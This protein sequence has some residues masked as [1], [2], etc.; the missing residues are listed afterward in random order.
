[1]YKKSI[2]KEKFIDNL[3]FLLLILIVMSIAS[4]II[5]GD[6]N[7]LFRMLRLVYV[8]GMI[9]FAG[10][11]TS[12]NSDDHRMILKK[13]G[14][15]FALFVILGT[16]K[17]TLLYHDNIFQIFIKIITFTKIPEQTEIFFTMLVVLFC[18]AFMAR[19][20][21]SISQHKVL[22]DIRLSECFLI[23]THITAPRFFRI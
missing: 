4:Q 23:V 15:Y 18:S 12:R 17:R 7:I 8:P 11:Y 6:K 9:F 5:L 10:Y 14:F 20:M 16:L 13:A 1:M 19:Y 3:E 22:L 21:N 2:Y